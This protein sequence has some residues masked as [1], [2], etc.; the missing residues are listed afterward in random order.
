VGKVF[1]SYS[2]DSPEHSERVL[3]LSNRLRALG[4]DAELDR[5]HV[6]P[7]QGW[8][9]WCEEQLRPDVS[10]FV[11]VICTPTYRARVENRVGADE[12]RGVYWEGAIL[13][14]YLYNAKGNSRFI[15]VLV[16][17]APEEAIPLPLDGHTRYRIRAFELADPGF[18]A[19]Y[20]ELTGQPEMV[21]PALGSVVSLGAGGA[22]QVAMALPEKKAVTGFAH[23]D[24]PLDES[25]PREPS[26]AGAG[27]AETAA[28]RGG[29]WSPFSN[30][31]S[32]ARGEVRFW[33]IV[34]T[35]AATAVFWWVAI[36]FE[37]FALLT[38]SLFVA[39]LLLLRSEESTRLGVKWVD[40]GMFQSRWPS[41]P[42]ARKE[43]ERRWGRRMGW[44]GA[45]IGIAVGLG[46]GYPVAKL[47]LMGHEGWVAF[48]RG[49]SFVLAT[50]WLAGA[51]AGAATG[52]I[53]GAV[54]GAVAMPGAIAAAAAG[55]VA[56]ALAGDLAVVVAGTVALAVEF[57]I[58]V[59]MAGPGV[60][61]GLWLATLIF[62]VIATFR[63]APEG[64]RRLPTNLRRLAV[65]M[66][67]LQQPELLPGLPTDHGIRFSVFFVDAAS[68]LG[69][70]N[71]FDRF[72]TYLKFIFAPP[73]FFSALAYRFILK[74]TL[75]FWWILFIVGG[76]PK[77]DGGIEGLRADAY[78]KASAWI[79]IATTVFAL[80]G[81]GFG[82]LLKPWAE[83]LAAEAPLPAA[84]ALL[85]LVDRKSVPVIQWVTL[86]SALTTIA[87]VIWTRDLYVDW[88]NPLRTEAVKAQLPWLGHLVK[89][90]TGFGAVGIALLMLYFAL[91]SNSVQHYFP[92]SD[93]EASW[94]RWLYGAAAERLQGVG[95]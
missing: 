17:D 26:S 76:A 67:P 33:A 79:G 18:E 85:V 72:Y 95:A 40:E 73:I 42:A 46:F 64:Y 61:R 8:P 29:F 83:N 78:R 9:H 35:L 81:F 54:P 11:L 23:V 60:F 71:L 66:S 19:I 49:V 57:A 94:L 50:S 70:S 86:L 36:R 92:I 1:I 7:L 13:Y 84:V 25:A 48:V 2:H 69:S 14:N 5:Y 10:S 88:Q 6:R 34:E 82:W 47:Y 20:R 51:A 58:V 43:A 31:E 74:S 27:T 53:T 44:I 22:P 4:V 55:A 32:V 21:K 30:E 63:H 89:W 90:K 75:W 91:Y 52:A 65:C 39:P 24:R 59:L 45:I 93:W 80:V 12:G 41:D 15:P 68:N 37:T 77:L 16:D 62:R 56:V 3:A 38:S 28:P 87:V